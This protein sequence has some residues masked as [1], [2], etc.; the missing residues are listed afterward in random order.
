M[1]NRNTDIY[2]SALRYVRENLLPLDANAIMTDFERALRN[3]IHS[4][5]PLTRSL[6]CWFHFCQALRRK[7][8]SNFELFVL[9]RHN[10][11]A[12]ILYRK[13]QC[14]ALLPADKIKHAFDQLAYEALQKFSAFTSFVSYFDT[15]WIQR[16]TPYS[17]SVFLQVRK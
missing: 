14:L 7:V 5:V 16:E 6:G 1:S 8:V 3:A 12:R 15:F 4:I 11:T 17:F 9:V 13:F 2:K 10:E